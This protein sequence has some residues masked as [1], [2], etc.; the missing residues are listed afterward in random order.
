MM[1]ALDNAQNDTF[2]KLMT[3]FL[4]EGAKGM[5][6]MM[7]ADMAL[8]RVDPVLNESW[9]DLPDRFEGDNAVIG[10]A[11]FRSQLN[12]PMVIFLKGKQG[13][14][15]ASLMLGDAGDPSDEPL[16]EMQVSALSEA[17]NQML[18]GATQAINESL[19]ARIDVATVNAK[20]DD[21]DVLEAMS[22]PFKTGTFYSLHGEWSLEGT[23]PIEF[24]LL[25]TESSALI[26]ATLA[27]ATA[28]IKE[29]AAASSAVKVSAPPQSA[30]DMVAAA[31]AG[32][33]RLEMGDAPAPTAPSPSNSGIPAFASPPPPAV[34]VPSP[35]ASSP[36]APVNP[37]Q[38]SA[39]DAAAPQVQ[40]YENQNLGLLMDINLN[41]HVEL[42]RT[43]M[44]I[45]HILEL[46]R[47]SVIELDR[48]A[49]EAVDLYANG[50]LIARGEVVVI[51]DNF[52]I[53]VTSIVS[54]AERL[55]G[56]NA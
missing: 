34:A 5:G 6:M 50:K 48:I 32:M 31:L 11:S 16:S 47:G 40:G 26:L 49:G 21:P 13:A 19:T 7:G 14:A 27:G 4:E 18:S 3:T 23:D 24:I 22:E 55:K 17:L 43:H 20:N 56:L 45:K 33:N 12:D 15:L 9:A 53:R 37:V 29:V 52:G 30:P 8:K 41:L 25:V 44:S 51:E 54:P 38:F 42:G 10:S 46:T 35:F 39:F 36:S 2:K 1:M 28:P